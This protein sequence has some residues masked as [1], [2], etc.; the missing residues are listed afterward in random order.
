M[1]ILSHRGYW[2]KPSEKNS[3]PA[4]MRSLECG[5]GLET[6]VRDC[7]GKIVVSHDMPIGGEVDFDQLIK[8]FRNSNRLLALNIKADGLAVALKNA[9]SAC[10]I[11]DWFVF[12]MSIPDMRAY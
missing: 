2:T 3:I 6:D 1:K 8:L 11:K 9:L 5:F 10:D 12:D 4:F 7:A